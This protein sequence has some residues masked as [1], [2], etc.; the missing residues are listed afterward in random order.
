MSQYEK[1]VIR[2][3]KAIGTVVDKTS[4]KSSWQCSCG[5]Q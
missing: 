5:G 2:I 4:P 1:P 3:V